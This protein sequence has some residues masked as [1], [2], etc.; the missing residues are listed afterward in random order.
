MIH[1]SFDPSELQGADKI[2]WELWQKRANRATTRAIKAWRDSKDPSQKI[3]LTQTIWSD[4]NHWL[5][6]HVFHNKCAYCETSSPQYWPD[7]EHYRPKGRVDAEQPGVT[8]LTPV[9]VSDHSGTPIQHPGYFWLAYDWRNLIPGC[10]NCNSGLGAPGKMNQFPVKKQYVFLTHLTPAEKQALKE[11]PYP[12]LLAPDLYYLRSTDLDDVEGPLLL[13]PYRDRPEQNLSFEH[14]GVLQPTSPEGEKTIKVCNLAY[15]N[16]RVARQTAQEQ[17][18]QTWLFAYG[19]RLKGSPNPQVA[20]QDA[21]HDMQDVDN[22]TA[23]YSAAVK[24]YIRRA[25]PEPQ[26]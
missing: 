11:E 25:F 20:W 23:A 9:Q 19:A 5:I 18:A 26:Q 21:W 22:G 6:Q 2:W 7:G 17:G 24:A 13:H 3:Q 14:G 8:G 15:E 10:R 12:S 1:I 16:L 4:L